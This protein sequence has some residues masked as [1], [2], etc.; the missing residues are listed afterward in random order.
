M[1]FARGNSRKHEVTRLSTHFP[2]SGAVC[3]GSV[4]DFI[5]IPTGEE[6]SAAALVLNPKK[7]ILVSRKS[8]L[9]LMRL[10]D[11]GLLVVTST[12]F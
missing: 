12:Y 5:I 6:K 3:S 4:P 9:S 1:N 7:S 8:Q 2:Q 11:V 10:C